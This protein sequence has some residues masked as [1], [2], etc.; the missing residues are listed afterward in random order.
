MGP[1]GFLTS[2][3]TP[4]AVPRV[5]N[6]PQRHA[7]GLF[8]EQLSNSSFARA[9]AMQ[10]F[11][12]VFRT[13]PSVKLGA[14]A[15]YEN[16]SR[17]LAVGRD[18]MD[19]A[20]VPD[21]ARWAPAPPSP[22]RKDDDFV[23]SLRLFA[24]AGDAAMNRGLSIYLYAFTRGMSPSQ[25]CFSSA[26]GDVLVVP[27]VGALRVRTEM[28]DLT[29]KPGEILV[30]PCGVRWSVDTD[31]SDGREC[32]GYVAECFNEGGFRLP[33]TGLMGPNVNAAANDFCTPHAKFDSPT[34]SEWTH[35]F[36]MGGEWFRGTLSSSPFNVVGWRGNVYPFTYDLHRFKAM[37][38]ISY[39]HPDPSIFTVLSVAGDVPGVS[40]LDFVVFP[41]RWMVAENTFRPP[42]FH[43]NCMSEVMG[44]VGGEYDGKKGGADGFV[45]G[46]LSLH[47][48]HTP[49]GP[50]VDSWRR[51]T[52]EELKPTK[53]EGG[54]AFMFETEYVLKVAKWARESPSRH[55]TYASKSW[56]GFA[57]ARL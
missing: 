18:A 8:A 37:G 45:P 14:N 48:K 21:P 11:T 3:A 32:R 40:A 53:Y 27:Q 2:E 30:V 52:D 24:T 12:W 44:L 10:R 25:S 1:S 36:K 22:T 7:L 47:G 54:L 33:E 6:N 13:A 15:R 23:A 31:E 57:S 9:R 19:V 35:T 16:V 46:G 38:S 4:G 39:D 34:E 56:G 17:E 26:D 42:Y 55:A 28:G 41:H 20:V 51:A 49:H 5:G 50:D 29:A 43:R